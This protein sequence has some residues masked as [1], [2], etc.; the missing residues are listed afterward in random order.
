MKNY[1]EILEVNESASQEI[2]EKAYK[3][4]IKKYHPD[5]YSGEERFFAEQKVRDLNE[6]YKILSDSFLR[7]QYNNELENEKMIKYN[8]NF[9]SNSNKNQDFYNSN[10]DDKKVNQNKSEIKSGLMNN[11]KI[12]QNS[13]VGTMG[14]TI[15]LVKEIFKIKPKKISFKDMDKTDL[16]ALYLTIAIVIVL[17]IIL[18][19]IPFTNG[20]VR[21]ITVDNPMFSWIGKIFGK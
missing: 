21:S 13:Q 10:L 20:F 5:L 8:R 18:W 2:I 12:N 9:I 15:D 16:K 6:A 1:Y 19:F 17:G 4:L 14:S 3:I 11:L 7:E